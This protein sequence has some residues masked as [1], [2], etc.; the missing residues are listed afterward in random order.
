LSPSFIAVRNRRRI[1][2]H[3]KREQYQSK[4]ISP[5]KRY[6]NKDLSSMGREDE[7]DNLFLFPLSG[8]Y[9][10]LP[11]RKVGCEEGEKSDTSKQ[12]TPAPV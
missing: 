2:T 11:K 5:K 6:A 9:K 12:A 7:E 3:Q 10:K 4:E 1:K 8:C